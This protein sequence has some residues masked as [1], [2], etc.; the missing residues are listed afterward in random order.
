MK[1][2]FSFFASLLVLLIFSAQGQTVVFSEDFEGTPPYNLTSSSPGIADWAISSNY[3][4]GG[5]YSDTSVVVLGDTAYLTSNSFSTIGNSFVLLEFSHICKINYI[6]AAEIE[7]SVDGGST[8]TKLDGNHY[9]GS[10]Q[11]NTQG[12]KFTAASYALWEPSNATT[13]DNGWWKRE[14]FD[15]SPIA[16]NE[17]DV[18]VRFVLRDGNNQG[19]QNFPGWFI[20]DIE[21]SVQAELHDLSVDRIVSPTGNFCYGGNE[22]VSIVIGNYGYNAINSGFTASYTIDG[23][24]PVTE[25]VSSTIGINDSITYIFTTPIN[26]TLLG[27]DSTVTIKTYVNAPLDPYQTNDSLDTE[28]TFL[29]VPPA[30]TAVDDNITYGNTAT[31]GA[32]SPYLIKWY[33]TASS[34][35]VLDT[36]ATFTTPVLYGDKSYFAAAES[37]GD[38]GFIFTEIC[39]YKYSVGQPS[40]GWPSYLIADDYVEITGA[41]GS[42]LG[43]FT[44]EQWTTTALSS[45]YTFPSG[46]V[47]SPEGTAI[48]AVG[49][50][51]GSSPSPANYYYHANVSTTWYSDDGAGRIIKDPYGNIVDAVGYPG[52]TSGYTF[53]AASGVTAAEWSGNVPSAQTTS[54]IRLIGPYTKDATNWVVS[55]STYPQDPNTVNTGVEPPSLGCESPRT[56]VWAYVTGNPPVDAGVTEITEPVSPT[57]LQNQNVVVSIQN[58][59]T[60]NLVSA[61][62]NWSINGTPQT[63]FS[64]S[65]NLPTSALDTFVIGTFTPSMGNNLIKAWTSNPNGVA[66]PTASND[67]ASTLIEAY[68]PLCGTYTIG[69][70]SADFAGFTEAVYALD[71]I[72]ITCPVTFLVNSGTY[73][74][75]IVLSDVLGASATNTITFRSA[76]GNPADVELTYAGTTAA[77]YVVKMDDAKYINFKKITFSATDASYAR[78]FEF[79]DSANYNVIDSCI[80][81]SVVVSTTS[82]NYAIIYKGSGG[83]AEYNTFS[84]NTFN[85]GSSGIY[86]YG[87]GTT[88]LSAGLVVENNNFNEQYYA[89]M[90]LYYLNAPVIHKNKVISNSAH[91]S[92]YGIS[93]AYCDNALEITKN[94][95][96]HSQSGYGIRVYYSDG[97]PSAKGLIA[98]NMVSYYNGTGTLYGIYH[99]YST[100]QDYY[101]NSIQ[102]EGTGASTRSLYTVSYTHLTL[103][104][105]RIV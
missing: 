85:D 84:N 1:T 22:Y 60:N 66:D 70:T 39:H 71:F 100:Y 4:A 76:S 51:N 8:W 26:F 35:T 56:E 80:L 78:V 75:Q 93:A 12:Y 53:P 7:V 43:G 104:T 36:G 38:G 94:T 73:N 24:T 83:H 99:Y 97:T 29:Y 82:N 3:Q 81:N 19:A 48:I 10:S 11:F 86:Y 67:S 52:G 101:Y 59:G 21:V 5:L 16:A 102:V 62:V 95:I 23:G 87:S 54:G 77:N 30:P 68:E 45:S 57:N 79:N 91:T 92:F 69:G 55:S 50:P 15:I 34:T 40:G 103:P 44:L 88:S 6:D 13:I 28:V 14:K 20:D 9:L 58:F 42:D 49:Q 89:G 25:N 72:G 74:E 41:P 64:W 27:Q 31:L 65:G 37:S 17:A 98:N 105:K 46:T 47:L 2:L 96:E 32:T 18:R 90:Y 33:E 61:T 63:P